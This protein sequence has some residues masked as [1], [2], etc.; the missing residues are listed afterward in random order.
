MHVRQLCEVK[1]IFVK[2]VLWQSSVAHY[3]RVILLDL[4]TFVFVITSHENRQVM[5]IGKLFLSQDTVRNTGAASTGSTS[6]SVNKKLHFCREVEMDHI[7]KKGNVDTTRGQV[8]DKQ[9]V[10]ML[11]SKFDQF[12]FTTALVHRTVN[13]R[14][15]ESCFRTQ[16]VHILNVILSSA[17]DDCLFPSLHTLS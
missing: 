10:Y 6:G 12:L 11:S 3:L 13:E 9:K 5:H 16:L 15:L 1:H 14:G 7:F 17:E 8:S 4:I 2:K